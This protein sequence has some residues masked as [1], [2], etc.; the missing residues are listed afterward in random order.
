VWQAR[1]IRPATRQG[2][3]LL[4]LLL[5]VVVVVCSLQCWLDLPDEVPLAGGVEGVVDLLVGRHH[6][7]HVVQGVLQGGRGRGGVSVL[8]VARGG[9]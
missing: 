2:L 4:L 3:P 5:L 6:P 1:L 9:A 8:A 7:G